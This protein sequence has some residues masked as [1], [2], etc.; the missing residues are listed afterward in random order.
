[1]VGSARAIDELL[2]HDDPSPSPVLGDPMGS[3]SQDRT[4]M[5]LPERPGP[6]CP[7]GASGNRVVK[8]PRPPGVRHR[9]SAAP[10][11]GR[12]HR[13]GRREWQFGA[14]MFDELG[15]TATD[16]RSSARDR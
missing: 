5:N 13:P 6:Q 3:A 16:G 7:I 2:E 15:F 14:W 11:G 1:M 9:A 10:F 12:G 8:C 4:F